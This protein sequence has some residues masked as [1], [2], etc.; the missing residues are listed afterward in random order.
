MPF[1]LNKL[2]KEQDHK[3]LEKQ[4]EEAVAVICVKLRKRNIESV[5]KSRHHQNSCDSGTENNPPVKRVV[6]NSVS[7]A[8]QQHHVSI[9]IGFYLLKL[10]NA[11]L[12]VFGLK[13]LYFHSPLK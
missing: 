8:K 11:W 4:L 7:V 9:I 10:G 12:P 3:L 6:F 13:V 2:P 5:G 1:S